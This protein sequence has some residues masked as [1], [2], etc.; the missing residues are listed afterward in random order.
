MA[1]VLPLGEQPIR[2]GCGQRL[3]SASLRSSFGLRAAGWNVPGS[4]GAAGSARPPST[5]GKSDDTEVQSMMPRTVHAQ[6]QDSCV[7]APAW[8]GEIR[9]ACDP[10]PHPAAPHP[11]CAASPQAG[12]R[13]SAGRSGGGAAQRARAIRRSGW[14]RSLHAR[15][16]DPRAAV[17]RDSGVKGPPTGWSPN[18]E[19]R[20]TLGGNTRRVDARR[21]RGRRTLTAR[22]PEGVTPREGCRS[23]RRRPAS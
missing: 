14:R 1:A 13:G 22:H 19:R 10:L 4:L 12:R 17:C 9:G 23:A 7:R 2:E 3:T 21:P 8:G 18:R 16:A 20:A 15:G 6:C 11:V 5:D